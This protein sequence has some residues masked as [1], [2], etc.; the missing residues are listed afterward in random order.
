MG[1]K[2]G[3]NKKRAFEISPDSETV[4]SPGKRI[5]CSNTLLEQFSASFVQQ[6]INMSMNQST[7]STPSASSVMGSFIQQTPGVIYHNQASPVTS[8]VQSQFFSSTPAANMNT[9]CSM[10][11]QQCLTMQQS[12]DGN[13]MPAFIQCIQSMFGQIEIRLKGMDS[14]LSKLDNIEAQ[15]LQMNEKVS[16]VERRVSS[17]ETRLTESNRQLSE[18]QASRAFDSQTCDEIKSAQTGLSKQLTGLSTVNDEL[19]RNLKSVSEENERLSEQL[20]D[21]QARS[22]RDNLL[23]F[24]ISECQTRE[25][26]MGE[27]CVAKILEFC[28][29]KL[30]ITGAKDIKIDRAHRLG[31]FKNDKTRPIVVKFNYF[32]DKVNVKKQASDKLRNTSFRVSDQYPKEIQDRRRA[33]YP[34][35]AQAKGQ[36][37]KAVLS[38]DKLY[39]D[40]NMYSVNNPPPGMTS[41]TGRA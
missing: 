38:Y 21:L 3:N 17:L 19:A 24:N 23:F 39:I 16:A 14:K 6:P 33:L 11:P 7:Q 25:E 35:F 41:G 18:I 40:G 4:F 22:M 9:Q 30:D 36:G 1:R 26:R 2:K 12:G 29:T 37:R 5:N 34:A 15:V 10:Q 27:D 31:S 13:S 20:L 32:Q 8:P 28:E